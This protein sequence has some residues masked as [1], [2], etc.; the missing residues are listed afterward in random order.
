VEHALRHRLDRLKRTDGFRPANEIDAH[1]AI[2]RFAHAPRRS[3][4]LDEWRELNTRWFEFATFLPILRV[5]GQAPKREMWEFGGVDSPA[6]T[7]MLKF[8]RLRYRLLPYVYSLAADV[9]RRG[10]TIMR[11]LAMDFPHAIGMMWGRDQE[12]YMFGP[13]FMIT[14]VTEY[15]ARERNVF[16]P[17][18]DGGWYD[19]WTGSLVAPGPLKAR[20]PLDAIPIH[21]RAGSIVPFGP[22]LQYTDER[23]ADPITLFVYGHRDGAFTLYEDDGVSNGYERG[24]FATIPIRWDEASSTLTIGK[25]A[26]NFPGMLARRTFQLVRIRRD[27]PVPF[28]FTPT[29]D[30]TI[31]YTGESVTVKL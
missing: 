20:A 4:A 14:P 6:Y 5:H 21:V 13:A 9:T 25:R 29:P 19:F 8:D 22:E 24:A 12:Q 16:L 11:P 17:P 31:V 28:S 30:K 2:C 7:A 10:G 18:A 1:L 27:R 23:P 26:G 3:E 15:R